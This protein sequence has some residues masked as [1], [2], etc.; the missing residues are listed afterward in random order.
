MGQRDP[1][2]VVDR[3]FQHVAA[4]F[5]GL[6]EE[7]QPGDEERRLLPEVA[8][9]LR[10]PEADQP[11]RRSEANLTLAARISG[12]D[13]EFV[14]AHAF[15]KAETAQAP[16]RVEPEQV[17]PRRQPQIAG[18]IALHPD[19][20]AFDPRMVLHGGSE[21]PLLEPPHV[22]F[23]RSQPQTA[24]GVHP[25]ALEI[26][27]EFLSGRH[28]VLRHPAPCAII[29]QHR[30][31]ID[32]IDL[33]SVRQD[34]VKGE[35]LR[36]AF[37]DLNKGIRG[38]A[39]DVDPLFVRHEQRVGI[40]RTEQLHVASRKRRLVAGMVGVMAQR[41]A[42]SQAVEAAGKRPR[43]QVA[44]DVAL[45]GENVVVDPPVAARNAPQEVA[46]RIEHVDPRAVGR[47]P[48]VPLFV[49]QDAVGRHALRTEMRPR[50]AERVVLH[51]G[52]EPSDREQTRK[53]GSQQHVLPAGPE[54]GDHGVEHGVVVVLA[55]IVAEKIV[56]VIVNR[57]AVVMTDPQPVVTVFAQTGDILDLRNAEL[58]G[59]LLAAKLV[60]HAVVAEKSVLD[61][62]DP[63]APFRV[64]VDAHPHQRRL[65]RIGEFIGGR[66]AECLVDPADAVLRKPPQLSELVAAKVFVG[67][68]VGDERQ[69]VAVAAEHPGLC[70]EQDFVPDPQDRAHIPDILSLPSQPRK[71][72]SGIVVNP[73]E[74]R[75]SDEYPFTRII[76]R[77]DFQSGKPLDFPQVAAVV[78]IQPL[79]GP[80][81]YP[82][83]HVVAQRRD[84]VARK[85]VIAAQVFVVP[86]DAVMLGRCG[87][88]QQQ[89]PRQKG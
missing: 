54:D 6:V 8:F 68:T 61:R 77:A 12:S 88:L 14:D 11:A 45:Q 2:R 38:I 51:P 9:Q 73:D 69:P 13:V 89:H 25:T 30:S 63:D 81:P 87:R 35:L 85:P 31:E 43:P 65:V 23:G 26:G 83:V 19:D 42:G 70:F 10:G 27:L 39:V 86:D 55:D 1:V 4:D 28:R 59:D 47:H 74:K 53:I 82:A 44:A 18:G 17:V 52:V 48:P 34:I 7:F 16:G 79:R 21:T 36:S 75:R 37:A 5:H 57:N 76:Q 78:N 41:P 24:L 84:A 40:E 33:V 29:T 71:A 32:E 64:G 72:A 58:P 50:R 20:P 46:R 60:G 22:A 66:H 67:S 49:A 3:V 62:S 15:G 56:V 80:D